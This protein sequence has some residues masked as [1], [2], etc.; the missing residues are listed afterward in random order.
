MKSAVIISSKRGPQCLENFL[1]I[2]PD[3]VDFIVVSKEKMGTKYDNTTE[4]NDKDAEAKSWIFNRITNR[5]FGFLYAYK[6]N[7]DIIMTLDDVRNY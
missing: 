3:N 1:D 2:A 7:Y 5:N 4:F 6:Q